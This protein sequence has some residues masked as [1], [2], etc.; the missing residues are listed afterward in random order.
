[1]KFLLQLAF[2]LAF[3]TSA[4]AQTAVN[5]VGSDDL[6]AISGF[7]VVAFHTMKKAISGDERFAIT[8]AGAKWTFSSAEHLKLFTD[9]PD[10]YLP[11]WGGHCAA[12]IA[13]NG[14]SQKKLSGDFTMV[15]NKLYLF[16][17]GNRSKSGAKDDFVYGR[18]PTSR[19]IADGDKNWIEI[20]SSLETGSRTQ[21]G[22]SSFRRTTYDK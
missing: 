2:F 7:D 13:E 9:A 6:M 3:V 8:H 12:G 10:R 5:T 1:M 16:S 15:G 14:V 17:W 21:P 18:W 11:A 19:L 20:K 4:S 22:A